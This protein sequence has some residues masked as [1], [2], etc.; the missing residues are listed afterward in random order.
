MIAYPNGT[1]A[2]VGDV[3]SLSHGAHSGV[4]KHVIESPA[5]I[6]SW[7]LQESGLMI[8]TSYG[9]YVF[10]PRPSLTIDEIEFLSR[11]AS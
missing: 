2:R 1:E 9:G 5:E 8:D 6:D 4:V 11:V 10:Y 3:V 7:N